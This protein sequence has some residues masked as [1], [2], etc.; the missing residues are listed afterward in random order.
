MSAIMLMGV[1]V[2]TRFSRLDG[3]GDTRNSR[4][5]SASVAWLHW[6]LLM[7]VLMNL[8]LPSAQAVIFLGVSAAVGTGFVVWGRPAVTVPMVGT[9][10]VDDVPQGRFDRAYPAL[11]WAVA[12]AFSALPLVDSTVVALFILTLAF[13]GGNAPLWGPIRAR[14]PN[15]VLHLTGVAALVFALFTAA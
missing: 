15:I 3:A 10:D 1:P 13:G 8:E 7:V 2:L 5:W 11:V 9:D 4:F 12:L 6:Y 14:W